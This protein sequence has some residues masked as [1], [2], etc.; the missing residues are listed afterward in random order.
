MDI[1][2]LNEALEQIGIIDEYESLIWTRRY[3]AAGD[4]ELYLPASAAVLDLLRVDRYLQ[5]EGDAGRYSSKSP[6]A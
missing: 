5:R 6:A 1:Y 3:Y 4:F 2:I